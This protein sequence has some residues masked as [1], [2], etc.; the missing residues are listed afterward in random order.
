MNDPRFKVVEP[1]TVT[2]EIVDGTYI[3][4]ATE[5]N[6]YGVAETAAEAIQDLQATIVELYFGLDEQRDALGTYLQSTY[7]TLET[8]LRKSNADNGA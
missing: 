5:I 7:R 1:F 6:G 2:W 3:I 8:K 4:R